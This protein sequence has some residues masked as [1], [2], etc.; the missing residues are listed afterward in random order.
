M[1]AC[2]CSFVFGEPVRWGGTNKVNSA[3]QCCNQCRDYVPKSDDDLSCN[4][5][6]PACLQGSPSARPGRAARVGCLPFKGGRA[7]VGS[8]WTVRLCLSSGR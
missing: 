7:P 2:V 4:G 6:P 1:R 5:A 3:R 8:H